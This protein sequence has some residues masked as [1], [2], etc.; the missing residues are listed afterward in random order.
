MITGN[1]KPENLNGNFGAARVQAKRQTLDLTKEILNKD[2]L[3]IPSRD[4]A[5]ERLVTAYNLTTDPK[6]R[7]TLWEMLRRRKA[8]LQPTTVKPDATPRSEFAE[9]CRATR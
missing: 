9:M 3:R 2:N 8:T 1:K 5:Y 6:M 4:D 7:E